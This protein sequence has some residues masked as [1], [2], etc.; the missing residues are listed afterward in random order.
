MG[1]YLP[2][3]RVSVKPVSHSQRFY[4]MDEF[5]S[6]RWLD[7]VFEKSAITFLRVFPAVLRSV[8]GHEPLYQR[9]HGYGV[10]L[11]LRILR[12]DLDAKVLNGPFRVGV[13][14]ELFNRSNQH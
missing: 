10:K 9:A 4:V 2:G 11:P 1:F 7:V 14:R 12:V 5:S 8:F 3:V 6:P 13:S